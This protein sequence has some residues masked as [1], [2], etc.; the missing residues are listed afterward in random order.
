MRNLMERYAELPKFLRR[1]FWR[2]WHNYLVS[3]DK[4]FDVKFMDYGFCPLNG[5]IPLLE[6]RK[7]DET[8]RYCINLYH[9]DVQ[10]VPLEN[11]DMLEIGCGRG[12]GAA[13]IARYL[14]PRSYIGLDLSTKA[15]K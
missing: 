14:K 10:D 4:N 9:H 1:P 12:G 2:I 3:H 5:E 8:E 7:E 13:Y 15:I 11:K 6:L